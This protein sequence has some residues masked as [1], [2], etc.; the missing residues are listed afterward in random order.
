MNDKNDCYYFID[1]IA[2]LFNYTPEEI[3]KVIDD[4]KKYESPYLISFSKKKDDLHMWTC[5]G[6][7]GRGI[8]LGFDKES[9]KNSASNFYHRYNI[10]AKLQECR[11]E[12]KR[13]IGKWLLATSISRE[14]I[15]GYSGIVRS[16]SDVSN[17]IKH[18]C[19][20]YEQEFRIVI[21]H[22]EK[23][24][25]IGNCYNSS[26]TFNVQ[27]PLAAIKKIIIGPCANKNA[28]VKKFKSFFDKKT[29]F[30]ESNIPYRC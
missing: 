30:V 4:K 15:L 1:M 16:V 26:D 12:N 5:Y 9:L 11:Y 22:G 7:N 14:S 21:E 27:I 6:D 17:C 24:C 29:Q 3:T 8:A 13:Q 25:C 18:P 20:K 2:A 28:I 10:Y 19:F 23:E